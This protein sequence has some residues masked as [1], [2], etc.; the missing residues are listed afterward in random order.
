MYT[1][2]KNR[3]ECNPQE[4]N[5]SPQCSLHSSEDWS[6]TSNIQQLYQEQFPLWHYHIIDT[7]IDPNRRC[8]SVIRCKSV[9]NHFTIDKIPSYK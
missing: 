3:T 4:Y 7:V 9:L 2:C 8:L 6:Q 5:R 1:T